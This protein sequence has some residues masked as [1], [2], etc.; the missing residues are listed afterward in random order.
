MQIENIPE[1]LKERNQWI[2]W[3]LEERKGKNT[4]IPYQING[5]QAQVNNRDTWNSFDKVISVWNE[6]GKEYNGIGFVFTKNDPYIGIDLDHVI[7]DGKIEDKAHDVLNAVKGYAEYSPSRTGF[8]IIVKGKLHSKGKRK[9]F[10]EMYAEGRYFTV[11]GNVYRKSE[12]S[13]QQNGIDYV[14]NKYIA[15]TNKTENKPIM[16]S[17]AE[18]I[19]DNAI[20]D[21]AFKEKRDKF[22]NL[23][24]GDMTEY[25]N[26]HSAADQALCNKLAF[27][28][29]KNAKQ[30]DRLFRQSALYREKWDE[31]HEPPNITYGQMTIREAISKC[32]DVYTI[33]QRENIEFPDWGVNKNGDRRLLFTSGNTEALMSYLGI[34]VKWDCIKRKVCIESPNIKGLNQINIDNLSV[35]IMDEL[36][37]IGVIPRLTELTYH[38]NFIAHRNSFN[39]VKD[40]LIENAEREIKPHA[41]DDYLDCFHYEEQEIFCK[42]LMRKWFIQTIAMIFN[43]KGSYGAEGIL[44]LMGTQGI[45]KTRSLSIPFLSVVPEHYY[46]KEATYDTTKDAHIQLTSFW[47]V[48]LSEMVRSFK[49]I[50]TFKAFIT[51][52]NDVIRLPYGKS[53]ADYPRLTSYCGTTND[54]KFLK[55]THNRRFWTVKISRID[56]DKLQNIDYFDFWAELYTE[57]SIFGDLSFRLTSEERNTLECINKNYRIK[58]NEEVILL[59]R[60][61]WEADES[62]WQYKTSTQI[63]EELSTINNKLSPTK[64][65]KA[66]S[67]IGYSKENEK[68]HRKIL[69]GYA[70]YK[71]PPIIA[72]YHCMNQEKEN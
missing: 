47:A 15:S 31:V 20:L 7:N 1:E 56:L 9:G 18:Y 5:T 6:H 33:P 68:K 45:G 27:Y 23:W 58:S 53:A 35:Y 10:I 14:Y 65:G 49:D 71:V 64:I 50:E 66:L 30:M 13:D 36:K 39:C 61:K 8:H 28:T 37:K 52:P 67:A 63:S 62:T 34:Y 59:E 72:M 46:K 17:S 51:S 55:D 70:L 44:T 2:L 42:T 3:R 19:D 24:I 54:E 57:F 25:N 16:P 29:R 21:V 4:K 48:E 22:K 40:F 32:L 11:T 41:V 60:L 26:D 43:E 38:L 69:D 12:I